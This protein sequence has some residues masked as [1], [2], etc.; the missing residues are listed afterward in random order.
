VDFVIPAGGFNHRPQTQLQIKETKIPNTTPEKNSSPDFATP[1]FLEEITTRLREGKRIRRRLP[2]GGRLHID[3]VVPFLCVHRRIDKTETHARRDEGT[4]R[5]VIGES[6]HLVASGAREWEDDLSRLVAGIADAVS[7]LFGAFLLLEVWAAPVAPDEDAARFRIITPKMDEM[8][9]VVGHLQEALQAISIPRSRFEVEVS[10]GKVAPPHRSVLMTTTQARRLGVLLIGLEVPAIYQDENGNLLPAALRFLQK[11]LSRALQQ[12]FFHF[13]TAHTTHRPVNFQSLGRHAPVRAVWEIDEELA[14]ISDAFQ[15]LLAV[16]PVN[17]GAAW[18]DFQSS[19][20][21]V[22]PIFHYRWLAIEPD[23]LKREL[24]DI[25]LERVEDP[26]LA[27]LL[28]NKR[29]ELSRQLTMLDDRDTPNFLPGSVQVYGGVDDELFALA[30]SL[31][32][33]LPRRAKS[34]AERVD[35]TQFAQYAREEIAYYSQML[36]SFAAKVEVR[37]DV[38]GVLVSQGS[39]LLSTYLDIKASR[40]QALLQ[41]EVGTHLLTY[42]NGRAQR[43]RLMYTGLA[44]YEDLQEGVAVLAEY[45]VGGLT[46]SR[47]RLLAARVVAVR[48][49]L[50]GADFVETFRRLRDDFEF[51]PVAAYNIAMRVFRGG[52][53]TKDAVYLRGLIQLLKHLG[54][55]GEVEPLFCGKVSLASLEMVHELQWREIV[56]HPRIYPRYLDSDAAQEKLKLLRGGLSISE[57]MAT[58]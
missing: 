17:A 3:R 4:P 29:D 5:L 43:L 41:H 22:A 53:L 18:R 40:V 35:A 8:P 51:S 32:K 20:F 57:L 45:F 16:T 12:T 2:G 46:S 56:Q 26:T 34:D 9:A 1:Q 55:G 14:K 33:E 11:E 13:M 10:H 31:L 27:T 7:D 49:L 38:S 54:E 47:L 48:A 36:P 6:S 52:G 42:Y 44:G 25:R 28:R 30:E 23:L 19:D 21:S 39:L 58:N 15:F 24:F 37:E 50:D